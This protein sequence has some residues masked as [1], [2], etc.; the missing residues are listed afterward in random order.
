MVKRHKTILLLIVT[1]VFGFNLK[2]GLANAQQPEI[3]IEALSKGAEAYEDREVIV[4]GKLIVIGNYYS[5]NSK[6]VILDENGNRFPVTTWLPITVARPREG[7]RPGDE[8]Q[9]M[10]YY[11]NKNLGS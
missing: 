4:R 9:V 5:S 1:L 11:L 7:F 8:K 10:S 2:Q 6:F 3:T